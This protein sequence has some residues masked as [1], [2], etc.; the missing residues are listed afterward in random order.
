M[1]RYLPLLA[2]PLLPALVGALFAKSPL[3]LCG[4]LGVLLLVLHYTLGKKQLVKSLVLPGL[5]RGFPGA[6]AALCVT[7]LLTQAI[8]AFLLGVGLVAGW[9]VGWLL[10]Y[11]LIPS[12]LLSIGL[13]MRR[14]LH[15]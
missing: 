10:P 6:I 5:P 7:C 2:Y 14:N 3:W 12:M 13:E 8:A 11:A 4:V 15:R 1:L 9:R